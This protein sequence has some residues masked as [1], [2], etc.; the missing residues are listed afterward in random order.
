MQAT[1][2]NGTGTAIDDAMRDLKQFKEE[3]AV[4]FKQQEEAFQQR[5]KAMDQQKK[6]LMDMM[7]SMQTFMMTFSATGSPT[8]PSETAPIF[9]TPVRKHTVKTETKTKTK[10]KDLMQ[11]RGGK[12]EISVAA[13]G[14]TLLESKEGKINSQIFSSKFGTYLQAC[15]V[16]QVVEAL[17]T[18]CIDVETDTETAALN[19]KQIQELLA[20]EKHQVTWRELL[21]K[22]KSSIDCEGE[23]NLYETLVLNHEKDPNENFFTLWFRICQLTGQ[24]GSKHEVS[25]LME[26]WSNLVFKNNTRLSDLLAS[27]DKIA[28]QV[29]T[30]SGKEIYSDMLKIDKLKSCL[31][32]RDFDTGETTILFKDF[33]YPLQALI[34][35]PNKPWA[36]VKVE[37]LRHAPKDNTGAER[38]NQRSVPKT[39]EGLA[40]AAT[41]SVKC[42]HCKKTGHIAEDC[43]SRKRHFNGFSQPN[44][45]CKSWVNEGV[46]RWETNTRHNPAG[47][48]CRFKHSPSARNKKNWSPNNPPTVPPQGAVNEATASQQ[49]QDGFAALSSQIQALT[50]ALTGQQRLPTVNATAPTIHAPQTNYTS[51]LM[52]VDEPSGSVHLPSGFASLVHRNNFDALSDSDEELDLLSD[53]EEDSEEDSDEDQV[54]SNHQPDEPCSPAQPPSSSPKKPHV[55]YS[56]YL[57]LTSMMILFGQMF[58]RKRTQGAANVGMFATHAILLDTGCTDSSS[59]L[60]NWLKNRMPS[61]FTMKTANSG[62]SPASCKGTATLCNLE[63]Q[64]LHVPDFN[65][66]LISWSDLDDMGMVMKSEQKKIQIFYPDGKLWTTVTRQ[67]DRLWHF[68]EVEEEQRQ[69]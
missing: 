54:E 69:M 29:N 30:I 31:Y 11:T 47:N 8:P 56:F 39:E 42:S 32:K 6:E 36:T 23:G 18:V 5:N 41:R 61:K 49:N 2:S 7:A 34:A 27:I 68:G 12:H 50:D 26:Q 21:T 58:T 40:N 45:E 9:V 55:F 64:V 60:L 13:K 59:G 51:V 10:L 62:I 4:L 24:T 44:Q 43:Y 1:D 53:S 57:L 65:H 63:L 37:F 16:K 17:Q 20:D 48:Q 25:T 14:I 33:A 3:Q 52:P 67:S 15:G 46:C 19:L 35:N 22:L 66:T 38:T 28:S